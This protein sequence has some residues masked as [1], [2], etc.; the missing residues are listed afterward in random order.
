MYIIII[1][2]IFNV[3]KLRGCLFIAIKVFGCNSFKFVFV[4]VHFS[5]M[6]HVIECIIIDVI[7]FRR[8]P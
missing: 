6:T 2:F 1:Y 8:K 3:F 5:A 4:Y 7:L